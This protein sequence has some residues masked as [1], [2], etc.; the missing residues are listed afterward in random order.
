[1]MLEGDL[2]QHTVPALMPRAAALAALP[3]IDLSA[4]TRVD[5]AG[6]AFLLELVRHR[7]RREGALRFVNVPA[8]LR[9]LAKFFAVETTLQL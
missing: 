4:V 8:Q 5:S 9:Q 1:M 7:D 3:Q 2:T 6:L